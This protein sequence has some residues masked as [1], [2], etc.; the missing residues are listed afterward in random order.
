MFSSCITACDN[1]IYLSSTSYIGTTTHCGLWPVE[2]FPSIFSYLPPTLSI[3][4]HPALEDL[5]L[6]PLSI[7]FWVFPF[8]SSLPVEWRSFWASYPSS[9]LSRWP[10]QLIL[11]PFTN[12]TIFSPLLISSSSR[13]A[14]LFHPPVSILRIIYS[15]HCMSVG[16]KFGR[17]FHKE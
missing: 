4:S 13:F 11:C 6:L 17:M 12:F 14:L 5:F 2:Q 10:N 16:H 1:S 9:I 15:K 3:F 7:L 8:F